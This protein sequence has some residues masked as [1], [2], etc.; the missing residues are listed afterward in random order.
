MRSEDI[1]SQ[2]WG[3]PFWDLVADFAHQELSRRATARAM[4]LDPTYF[5]L[6]LSDNPDKDPFPTY[7]VVQSYLNDTGETFREALQRMADAGMGV[8]AVAT[9]I[10]FKRTNSLRYAMAVR[11]IE[12]DFPTPQRKGRPK[13]KGRIN[14]YKGWP[15]WEK[16]N[17]MGKSSGSV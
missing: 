9:A 1:V 3:M 4:G 12:I 5:Y 10:G 14:M 15:T 8:S 11:G 6:L 13:P 7:T 2:R 17:Q 16:I